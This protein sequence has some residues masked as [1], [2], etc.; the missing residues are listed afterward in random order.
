MPRYVQTCHLPASLPHAA[1]EGD[2][3]SRWAWGPANV[4][5]PPGNANSSEH[6]VSA[7]PKTSQGTC[8]IKIIPR[9]AAALFDPP[10][11]AVGTICHVLI[12]PRSLTAFV[13]KVI[14]CGVVV[15]PFSLFFPTMVQGVYGSKI[16]ELHHP[17][18]VLSDAELKEKAAAFFATDDDDHTAGGQAADLFLDSLRGEASELDYRPPLAM[19]TSLKVNSLLSDLDDVYGLTDDCRHC[20]R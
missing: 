19:E 20:S 3:P 9:R 13:I 8:P 11:W 5:A 15:A 17:A 18:V 2:W 12:V 7:W 16:E 1:W 4:P 6:T 10:R 14:F